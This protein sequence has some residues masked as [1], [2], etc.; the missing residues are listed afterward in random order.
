MSANIYSYGNYY[1]W[2]A[3]IADI[4]HYSSGD[5]NTT[6]ICPT[7]WHIPTA[8]YTGGEFYNLDIA[9]GG[10][11]SISDGSTTPTGAEMSQKYRSYP[12]NFILSS[13]FASSSAYYKGGNAYY[14]T[15]TTTAD[16]SSCN[17][18]FYSSAVYP[19]T[20]CTDK[21]VGQSIRCS[22]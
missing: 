18:Y 22:I 9:M 4:A 5:H 6:S 12:A 14:W 16:A 1:T 2:A 8:G 7:G 19:G 21:Y 11:G 13:G 17:L 3:A 15:S 20:F 10:T